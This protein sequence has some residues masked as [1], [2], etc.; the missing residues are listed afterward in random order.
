MYRDILFEW[1]K[2]GGEENINT[3]ISAICYANA[4]ITSTR[5]EEAKSTLR[6]RIP[7]ARRVLGESHELT[8]KMR[9]FYAR[10][11]YRDPSATLDNVREA[12]TTIEELERTARRVLGSAHPTTVATERDLQNARAVLRARETP[13]P[14]NA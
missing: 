4:L 5:F 12:V 13:S 7:V 9:K 1:L 2:V 6:R 11:L 8:L 3:H 14:G 10:A